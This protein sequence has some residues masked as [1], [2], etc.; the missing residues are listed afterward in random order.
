MISTAMLLSRRASLCFATAT[1]F[2]LLV[3]ESTQ[4][5]DDDVLTRSAKGKAAVDV[6]EMSEGVQIIDAPTALHPGTLAPSHSPLLKVYYYGLKKSRYILKYYLIETQNDLYWC[7]SSQLCGGGDAN[8]GFVIDNR[9]GD[10]TN[11]NVLITRDWDVFSY[12][13]YLISV[14]LL[15]DSG[16]VV[17]TIARKPIASVRDRAP[18]LSSIGARKGTD[19]QP[20]SFRVS[21]VDPDNDPVRYSAV[22]LPHGAR[23]DARTGEFRWASPVA[24]IYHLAIVARA[25]LLT[26]AEAIDITV[27][28]N[29]R[30]RG[31]WGPV[32]SLPLES[33]HAMLLPSAE[34]LFWDRSSDLYGWDG[35][36]YLFN[37]QT[38]GVVRGSAPG[39]DIFC[40]G[41]ALDKQGRVVVAGGHVPDFIGEN[42]AALLAR[43]GMHQDAFLW[44]ALSNMNAGCCVLA[45][46]R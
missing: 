27:G 35:A 40:S 31:K 3:I 46:I 15:N 23:L 20:I 5:H 30:R 38:A 42:Q 16:T 21:A 7:A 19:S 33:I 1:M 11:G 44:R 6:A 22:D 2:L 37:L 41:M 9:Q 29:G 4:A 8:Q 24:G 28:A 12:T 43:N 32:R 10:A 25:G 17:A 13:G 34:I 26:D 14:D 39:F 36:P 18:Q 45:L